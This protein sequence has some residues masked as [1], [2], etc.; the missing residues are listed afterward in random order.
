MCLLNHRS[1]CVPLLGHLCYFCPVSKI[2]PDFSY[3]R[4]AAWFYV[5]LLRIATLHTSHL[6]LPVPVYQVTTQPWL[7]SSIHMRCP[8][9]FIP[10]PLV[11]ALLCPSR[12]NSSYLLRCIPDFSTLPQLDC[13][14]FRASFFFVV[15]L[16]ILIRFNKN[17]MNSALYQEPGICYKNSEKKLLS[18]LLYM[19]RN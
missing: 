11:K 19:F 15:I 1:D 14:G 5:P 8:F 13:Y 16:Y 3:P 4:L 10:L 6:E 17:C 7:S 12:P 18:Y 2:K 9:S